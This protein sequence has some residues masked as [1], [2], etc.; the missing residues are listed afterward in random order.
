MAT[1]K[2]RHLVVFQPSGQ[3]GYIAEGTCLLDA[4]RELG[5][6]LET[7]CGRMRTCGKCKVRVEDGQFDRYG[8]TSSSS[9]L[10]TVSAKEREHLGGQLSAGYRLACAARVFGGVVVFV[11]EES[12]AVKQ[13][14]CK[15]ATERVINLQPAVRKLYVELQP[16]G[17]QDATADWERLARAMR[18]VFELDHLSIDHRALLDLSPA[19][20]RGHWRAT[21][22][23]WRNREVIRVEPGLV[24]RAAGLAVDVGTTTVAG[25][26]CDLKTGALLSTEAIMNPQVAY[27]E[28]VISRITYALRHDDGLAKLNRAIVEGLDA[29]IK[30]ATEQVGLAWDDVLEIVVVGNT[31]MHHLLMNLNPEH[32]GKVPF[33][34][35]V[36]HPLD[37][38]ARDLGLRAHPSANVH[39]MPLEAGFVGADNVAV[40]IAEQ[41][42]NQDAI[43]LIVDIGTNGEL[44]LGNREKLISSS[45]ATGPALEG[46][47]IGFGMRAAPG[48]IERVRIDLESLEPRLR[49]IGNDIWS[50]ELDPAEIRARGIC[51]SGIVEAVA[52]MFRTGII[53]RTGRFVKGRTHPRLRTGDDGP[54][55]VVAWASETSIGK[56]IAVSI[57]DVRAIQLAKA[58]MYAGAK[59]MMRR[60]GVKRVDR[61]VLAGAFGNNID[62][63]RAMLL[64][65]FPDCELENVRAVGNAAGD[66]ARIALLDV[67][68]REEADRV[69]RQVEY[70]ELTAEPDFE[71]EF[72]EATHLPHMRDPFPNLTAWLAR[73]G[74][75]AVCQFKGDS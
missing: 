2:S 71:R 64:G 33:V 46:A 4:A 31:A 45:C 12:R 42:Y 56:D 18:E 57:K 70:V 10:S 20:R 9:H 30:G 67:D 7:I 47:H 51:G 68:K 59:T 11:P 34:P 73:E 48:A 19:L 29:I 3:R 65:L 49:V 43:T 74:C 66:G 72:I 28:D 1:G 50:D 39:F 58:A 75:A 69:A 6:G 27:G 8:I 17:L 14:V 25:Y 60:L 15:T 61:V 26:L 36:H 52:E 41:P 40:L 54:E 16:P 32:L 13:V 35:T 24:D 62:K 55:Y 23:L 38:K 22:T 21:V 44:V 63:E 53:D 5:V 37:I